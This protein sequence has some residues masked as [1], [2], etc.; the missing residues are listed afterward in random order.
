[1]SL[2][3]LTSAQLA[4]ILMM[5][6]QT[7]PKSATYS[8]QEISKTISDWLSGTGSFLRTDFAEFRRALVDFC[9]LT[10]DPFG[11]SYIRPSIWPK[12]WDSMC[13]ACEAINLETLFLQKTQTYEA[14]R[15]A[16]RDNAVRLKGL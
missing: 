1:M 16:R 7:V 15:Q 4:A 5:F 2:G 3:T 8:E 13:G 6:T 10:R 9:F 12:A 11:K 14:E